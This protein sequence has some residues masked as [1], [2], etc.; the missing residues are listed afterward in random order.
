VVNAFLLLNPCPRPYHTLNFKGSLLRIWFIS[1]LATL[2]ILSANGQTTQSYPLQYPKEKFSIPLQ[3]YLK[4]NRDT[5]LLKVELLTSDARK[6]FQICDSS[7]LDI[8]AVRES[9]NYT[10]LIC[11]ISERILY[12]LAKLDDVIAVEYQREA[13]TELKQEGCDFTL[14]RF[15]QVQDQWPELNG[16]GVTLC[17]KENLFDTS[18]IDF[19]NRYFLTP[20]TSSLIALHATNMASMAAGGGNSDPT[21][22]GV[23]WDAT[24][25]SSSFDVLLPDPDTYFE[26]HDIHVQNHSYGTSIENYYGL[27]TKAYDELCHRKPNLVHVFSSGNNGNQMPTEGKYA[28][29]PGWANLTGQFKQSKNTITVGAT[30]SLDHVVKLSSRGPAYD[31]RLKPEVVAYGHG[32]TSGSTA[33]VSGLS[34]LM[35]DAFKKIHSDSF[36]PSSLVKAILANTAE[37]INAPGPDFTSGFGS[38]R[39]GLAIMTIEKSRFI[40]SQVNNGITRVFPITVP[41]AT[42]ELKATLVWTDPATSVNASKALVNDLDLE[43]RNQQTGEIFQPWVLSSYP[44][45]DS[46]TLPARRG[47]D[48]L[49]NI[50]QITISPVIEGEYELWV[51]G[52]HVVD[53]PQ[54]FSLTWLIK[55]EIEFEWVF[56]SSS[57]FLMPGKQN[58]LRWNS[59]DTD[60]GRIEYKYVGSDNWQLAGHSISS[61]QAS[62]SWKAPDQAGLMQFRWIDMEGITVSDTFVSASQVRPQVGFACPDSLLFYWENKKHADSFEILKLGDRHM[63]HVDFTADTFYIVHDLGQVFHYAVTPIFKNKKGPQSS[64]FDYRSQGAGCYVTAFYLN[65]IENEHA[66]FD[67]LLSSLYNVDSLVLE[68]QT[69]SGF[70]VVQFTTP[71]DTLL[72]H[73]TSDELQQGISWFRLRVVLKNGSAVLSDLV[74]VYYPGKSDILVFPNPVDAQ[75]ELNIVLKSIEDFELKI[76]DLM[77]REILYEADPSNPGRINLGKLISGLYVVFIQYEGGS[78]GARLFFVR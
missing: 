16:A 31:G 38:V 68:I 55:P 27:E 13:T 75:G 28:G 71:A 56:P 74:P 52:S 19:R 42:N 57:D 20:L 21:S 32:G 61:S 39:A 54:H 9:G 78:A 45:V 62:F 37:D 48:T 34:V 49:N 70:K 6:V 46:L 24:L 18:D 23:A 35:D 51:K 30:D 29:L 41:A 59:T 26:D 64:G 65:S 33:M 5:R 1:L 76:T 4:R 44:Q 69:T 11:E 63:E 53:E 7:R 58:L 47:I 2:N 50:E 67:A 14:N 10:Y 12:D 36:P 66:F 72:F 22:K 73:F 3:E 8:L 60:T 15:R 40:N 25:T 77:G 43:I 17:L